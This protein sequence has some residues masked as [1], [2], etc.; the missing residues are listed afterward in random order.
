MKLLFFDFWLCFNWLYFSTKLNMYNIEF[1]LFHMVIID[2]ILNLQCNHVILLS[3][4]TFFFWEQGLIQLCFQKRP[5][6]DFSFW[7]RKILEQ[8]MRKLLLFS[9]QFSPEMV[10]LTLRLEPAFL[11]TF[12]SNFECWQNYII[13]AKTMWNYGL[14]K[15][16]VI[17]RG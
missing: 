14:N 11:A 6:I 3:Y 4:C 13:V 17:N 2:T 12:K 8:W 16:F 1:F 7:P 9:S 15:S 5:M 10:H